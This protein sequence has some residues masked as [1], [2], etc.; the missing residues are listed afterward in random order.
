MNGNAQRRAVE[1][2]RRS[3]CLALGLVLAACAAGSESA[4]QTPTFPDRPIRM[5]VGFSAG[6]GTDVIAR[7][8]AQKMSE[9]LGV[10]VVVENRTGASGLIAAEA[11]AKSAAD[12]YTLMMGSQTTF[13]V[14]PTLYRK[15][16]LDPTKEFAGVA[17][18]GISP[19]VLVVH[20]TVPAHSV[21][22]VIAMAKAAPGAINFGSGGLGTTPHMAAELFSSLAGIKMAHVAYRGEA[23]AINDLLGGQIPLMFANLSAVLGNVKA[24]GLRALAV[25]SARRSAA[26]PEI[27]TVAETALSDFEAATWFA[28]VAP[29]GTARDVLARLNLEVQRALAQPDVKQRF[30]DLGMSSEERTPDE[31]DAY[32]RAEIAKWTK[33]IKDADIRALE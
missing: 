6:G 27:P 9:T 28:L 26:A 19:L 1:M 29:V 3:R 21:E 32:I 10:S 23:P 5:I 25:T 4:A 22:D 8:L 31:L 11:V 7:I 33:V 30:A 24:G 20:P 13:A 16:A 17:M 12:G 18:A 15:S 2:M 14:A